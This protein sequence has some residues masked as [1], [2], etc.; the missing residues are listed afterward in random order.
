MFVHQRVQVE[1]IAFFCPVLSSS[2]TSSMAATALRMRTTI[3]HRWC[4]SL[5]WSQFLAK[6]HSSV[7]LR[8]ADECCRH[9]WSPLTLPGSCIDWS[10]CYHHCC[11]HPPE[12]LLFLVLPTIPLIPSI[13]T[14]DPERSSLDSDWVILF[15][16]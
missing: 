8:P 2:S 5:P 11:D 13:L 1:L 14:Q 9:F 16:N 12:V 10:R 7:E 15:L 4:P 3:S 6:L